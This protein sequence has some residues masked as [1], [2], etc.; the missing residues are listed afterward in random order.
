VPVADCRAETSCQPSVAA[1]TQPVASGLLSLSFYAQP[2]QAGVECPAATGA[3][4]GGEPLAHVVA[5]ATIEVCICAPVQTYIAAWPTAESSLSPDT[6]A[7]SSVAPSGAAVT[8]D[9]VA[10]VAVTVAVVGGS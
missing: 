1:A 6:V 4:I 5:A 2:S 10:D 7:S 8:V 3:V 9:L